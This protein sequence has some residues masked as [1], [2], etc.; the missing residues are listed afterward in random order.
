MAHRLARESERGVRTRS[1]IMGRWGSTEDE[2]EDPDDWE[3]DWSVLR[4]PIKSKPRIRLTPKES[5]PNAITLAKKRVRLQSALLAEIRPEQ[6][7]GGIK[8]EIRNAMIANP[9]ITP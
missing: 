8:Q 9:D 3:I 1:S 5:K 4:R 7:E 2:P 6:E